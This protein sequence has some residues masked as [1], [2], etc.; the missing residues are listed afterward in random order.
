MLEKLLKFLEN[1]QILILG[2]G[3]EGESTYRFLRKYFPEKS[4]FI[5]D[6]NT[7]ILNKHIELMEDPYLEVSLGENYLNGIEKYELIIKAPGISLKDQ[8]TS[9][10]ENPVSCNKNS[11]Y[12][13]L[14][15]KHL[16]GKKNSDGEINKY[17]A[18]G[19]TGKILFFQR[20]FKFCLKFLGT[21]KYMYML[22]MFDYF[23]DKENQLFLIQ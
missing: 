13:L 1:K 12:A 22:K 10:Y 18:S 7:E 5:A 23:G 3:M 15:K 6:K 8:D 19:L 11:F 9:K 16:L 4:L 17:K 14:K 21:E 20:V 2:F